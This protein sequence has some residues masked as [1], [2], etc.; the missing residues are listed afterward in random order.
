MRVDWL[1][2]DGPEGCVVSRLAGGAGEAG[3]WREGLRTAPAEG[4]CGW[5]RVG[6]LRVALVLQSF[7]NKYP[8]RY[9]LTKQKRS[10]HPGSK[11]S[12]EG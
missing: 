7:V 11:S 3:G 10:Y 2:A 5:L 6:Y 8:V 1:R 4:A 9:E 12:S